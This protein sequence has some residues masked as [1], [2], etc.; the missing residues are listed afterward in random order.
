MQENRNN[1]EPLATMEV[2][3]FDARA[4]VRAD[5]FIQNGAEPLHHAEIIA[6]H[7]DFASTLGA[8]V[9]QTLIDALRADAELLG[10]EN[11][12][13]SQ[14]REELR[15]ELMQMRDARPAP[16]TPF[17]GPDP[18]ERFERETER[19]EQ[20]EPVTFN[21]PVGTDVVVRD[22]DGEPFH[23]KTAGR[24]FWS[25][26]KQFVM[27]EGDNRAFPVEDVE[28]VSAATPRRACAV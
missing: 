3:I 14:E 10:K 12:E 24:A 5:V 4:G 11:S 19:D 21:P 18:A 15:A 26:D 1:P 16:G 28:I 25:H 8:V 17:G 9:N 6:R 2:H 20:A 22:G 23:S 13:L 7:G 27:V